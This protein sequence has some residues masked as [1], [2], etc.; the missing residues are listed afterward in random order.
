M[1]INEFVSA[2]ESRAVMSTENE[3]K[4][5]LHKLRLDTKIGCSGS[6]RQATQRLLADVSL[7][8]MPRLDGQTPTSLDQTVCYLAVRDKVK[9]LAEAREWILVEELAE[10]ACEGLFSSFSQISRIEILIRKFVLSDC[11]WV[12][13]EIT[14]D[15]IELGASA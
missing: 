10:A 13:V 12:G 4:I 2:E 15:R 11:D 3:T 14:R 5:L 9:S 1:S 7:V 8:I 6:E